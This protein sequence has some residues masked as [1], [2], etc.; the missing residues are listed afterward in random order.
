MSPNAVGGVIQKW[1]LLAALFSVLMAKRPL[2]V[3]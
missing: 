3:L 2:L 1:R